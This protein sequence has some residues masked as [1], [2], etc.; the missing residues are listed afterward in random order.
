MNSVKGSTR[1]WRVVCGVSPQ[2][3]SHHY[4]ILGAKDGEENEAGGETPI[5]RTGDA[6]ATQV[7]TIRPRWRS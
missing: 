2:T 1:L 4:C 6:C 5:G 7:L 3:S